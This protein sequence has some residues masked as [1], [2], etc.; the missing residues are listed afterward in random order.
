[1]N[2]R[3]PWYTNFNAAKQR[4]KPNKSYWKHGIKFLLTLEDVGF[5]WFRDKANNL[6]SPSIDRINSDE[7][8]ILSNCRFIEN[9]VNSGR[10][11]KELTHCKYG[12]EFTLEN[13]HYRKEGHRECR[14]CMLRRSRYFEKHCR[15]SRSIKNNVTRTS[16]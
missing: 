16:I 12:H 8:Y 2:S 14:I 1:M 13:T 11:R 3:S 5:L 4:C 9:S 7:D 15:K 10:P 6:K